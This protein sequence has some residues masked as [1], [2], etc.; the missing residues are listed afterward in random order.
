GEFVAEVQTRFVT[1][2]PPGDPRDTWVIVVVGDN[3]WA[4]GR[5]GKGSAYDAGVRSWVSFT[6]LKAPRSSVRNY[7]VPISTLDVS[8]TVLRM[9]RTSD[10]NYRGLSLFP[11]LRETQT[12]AEWLA[13]TGRR[14]VFNAAFPNSRSRIGPGCPLATVEQDVY[15]A[16]AH[17]V[18]T[19]GR[20]WKYIVWRRDIREQDF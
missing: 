12:Q 16:Y 7:E 6:S 19:L 18:D 10:T 14:T 13:T 3:G 2:Q 11:L 17:H 20:R 9:G 4:N 5:I 1:N 8:Q 15:A